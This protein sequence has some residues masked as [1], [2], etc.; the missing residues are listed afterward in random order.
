MTPA[1][2]QLE[3]IHARLTRA[4]EDPRTIGL[5]EGSVPRPLDD[6]LRSVQCT[7][8]QL[9]IEIREEASSSSLEAELSQDA[10]R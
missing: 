9:L 5:Q 4:V 1:V 8:G 3:E 6:L 7:L 2:P 10:D